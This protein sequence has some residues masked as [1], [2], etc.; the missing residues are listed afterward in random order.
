ME[1]PSFAGANQRTLSG[2]LDTFSHDVSLIESIKNGP[3]ISLTVSPVLIYSDTYAISSL[4]RIQKLLKGATTGFELT[5]VYKYF[6]PCPCG[7][8]DLYWKSPY[9]PPIPPISGI[10]KIRIGK[11][12]F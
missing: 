7:A 3:V 5:L 6:F 8:N 12:W 4:S 2:V 10:E 1:D 11:S 9:L